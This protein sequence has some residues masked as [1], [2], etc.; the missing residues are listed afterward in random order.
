MTDVKKTT[1]KKAA[2]DFVADNR[3]FEVIRREIFVYPTDIKQIIP[4]GKIV[5]ITFELEVE[6]E[7]LGEIGVL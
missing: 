2:E 5:K 7:N 4:R 1:L 3:N 6:D